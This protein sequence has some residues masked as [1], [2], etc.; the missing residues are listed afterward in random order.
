VVGV[1]TPIELW[2]VPREG[3]T[4]RRLVGLKDRAEKARSSLASRPSGGAPLWRIDVQP[5]SGGQAV[6]VRAFPSDSVSQHPLFT[7]TWEVVETV[8][9]IDDVLEDFRAVAKEY[10]ARLLMPGEFAPGQAGWRAL[11]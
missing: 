1:C 11:N 5:S 9:D 3:L 2:D 10:G 8:E 6:T 4:L 7:Y